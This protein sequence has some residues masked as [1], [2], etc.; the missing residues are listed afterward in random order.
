MCFSRH[1]IQNAHVHFDH[2][3]R[4]ANDEAGEAKEC[5]V[6]YILGALLH[7]VLLRASLKHTLNS[8]L[9]AAR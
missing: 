5:A 8:M 9:D 4:P 7:K 2:E 1:L 3:L 6:N